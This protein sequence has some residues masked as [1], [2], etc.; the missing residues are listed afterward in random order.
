MRVNL[1]SS[2]SFAQPGGVKKHILG[3]H[4]EFK[5][6][7]IHS[8]I[9]A[10][11][12]QASERYGKDIELLGT[13]IPVNFGGSQGD[14][15][16]HFNPMNIEAF[17][18]KGKFD[19]LHFHNFIFPLSFQILERSR[20][21]NILT[22]HANLDGSKFLKKWPLF[23]FLLQKFVDWKIDGIIGVAP[24]NLELFKKYKGPKIVIPNGIDPKEFNPKKPKVKK[25]RDGKINILFLSRIEE[26]KGLVYLLRAYKILQKKFGAGWVE[27]NLRLIIVGEGPLK[28]QL[29]A[30]T[31]E[32]GLK[33]VVFEGKV[34][35]KITASYFTTCDIY[36]EPAIFGESFGIVLVEAMA[37]GKPVVAFANKGYKGVLG[38]GKGKRFLSRPRDYKTLAKHLEVLI[39]DPALRKKMGEWGIEEAKKYYWQKIAARV[40]DFYKLCAKHKK[41]RKQP[42]WY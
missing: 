36:C 4:Q 27:K 8:K 35:E 32:N 26:R 21:L 22:F 40:L 11:R 9:A 3:L 20:S 30:W 25:Y 39:K 17:L 23:L 5:R 31:K 2:H 38:N 10:P 6:L 16:V 13:S 24:L 33:N 15:D 41:A 18:Q 19:V 34:P 14:L 1:I 7:G 42:T 28:E 37:S 29:E 12:R